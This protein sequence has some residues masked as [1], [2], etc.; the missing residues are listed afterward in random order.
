MEKLNQMEDM[1]LN[2]SIQDF[3][4]NDMH[5]KNIFTA[6]IDTISSLNIKNDEFVN[7][8]IA[9]KQ[10]AVKKRYK[11]FY[12]LLEYSK[13]SANP[14]GHLI[15]NVFG[16]NDS[17]ESE[18]YSYS[19]YICTA[20]QLTNFWQDVSLDLKLNRIYIPEEILDENNYTYEQLYEKVENTNFINIMKYLVDETDKIFEN[21]KPLIKML[22]GRIKYEIKAI[23][24]GGTQILKSIRDNNYK[25]LSKRVKLSTFQKSTLIFKAFL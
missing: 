12:E 19:D 4:D 7:L 3:K 2:Y 18:Y 25:V 5:F 15:L 9:F 6:L 20:L 1:L 13:Y 22:N 21:G 14:V 17:S 8:L 10:D 24:T 11:E 23:Y 16:I